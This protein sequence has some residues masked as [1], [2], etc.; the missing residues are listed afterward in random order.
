MLRQLLRVLPSPK[1]AS[2]DKAAMAEYAAAVLRQLLQLQLVGG[3]PKAQ[4]AAVLLGVARQEAARLQQAKQQ[5]QAGDAQEAGGKKEKKK[6]KHAEGADAGALE[7][8]APLELPAEGQP[9]LQLLTALEQEGGLGQPEQKQEEQPR[10]KK[11]KAKQPEG[12]A[13][14]DGP[15]D[16]C[17]LQISQLLRGDVGAS[18]AAELLAAIQ[19]HLAAE[20]ADGCAA[21]GVGTCSVAVRQCLHL[22]ER[23]AAGSRPAVLLQLLQAAV[24]AAASG[25]GVE[26]RAR[27]LQL[28][29]ESSLAD[30]ALTASGSARDMAAAAAECVPLLMSQLLGPASSSRSKG[31]GSYGRFALLQ[32]A[33]AAFTEAAQHAA[34]G[35]LP[36]AARS[37]LLLLPHMPTE[38]VDAAAE[39]L[40]DQLQAGG[41]DE[42]SGG[43]SKKGSKKRQAAA[44]A[45]AASWLAPAAA[46]VLQQR[47]ANGALT[48][49]RF[50][51]ACSLLLRLAAADDAA[52]SAAAHSCLLQLLRSKQRAAAL[53]ALGSSGQQQLLRSCLSL[54]SRSS[55]IVA[56]SELAAL[57]VSSG[58]GCGAVAAEVLPALLQGGAASL[59]L[60]LPAAAALLEQQQQQ[61]AAS[62]VAAAVQHAVLAH[63]A[64]GGSGGEQGREEDSASKKKKKRKSEDSN[65][66]AADGSPCAEAQQLLRQHALPCLRLAL[67]QQ[68]VASKQRQELLGALLPQHGWP[69]PASA[70]DGAELGS[71]QQAEAAVLLLTAR[72]GTSTGELAAGVRCLAA[73]LASLLK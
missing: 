69:V 33:A 51:Q 45:G 14:L 47:L 50:E 24:H 9:L 37:F 48:Q 31:G 25:G 21:G 17:C 67:Q 59:A 28:L 52:S 12:A 16:A 30:A 26:V 49:P 1:I 13:A 68:P 34:G 46:A 22:L 63:F 54:G 64:A 58:D 40:L 73:T 6:R 32:R 38:A 10:K 65:G 19:Q 8:S 56:R 27:C 43:G 71:A 42:H 60:A 18:A 72:G 62:E 2:A 44:D 41:P 5:Q 7:G 57:L 29:A 23:A 11:K 4:L 3:G 55:G 39:M 61:Q 53:A 66:A 35:D 20:A 70:V 15:I 36:P